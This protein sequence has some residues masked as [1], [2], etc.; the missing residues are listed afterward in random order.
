MSRQIQS[1]VS[2]VAK[3]IGSFTI[4]SAVLRSKSQY[5]F[6]YSAPTGTTATS[7]GIIGT[8]TPNGFEWSE[9][10]GIQAQGF[11]SGFD[12]SNIE[13]IYHGDSAGYVYNHNKGNSFNPAGV[14]TSVDARYKTPNL[15]F[16]DAGTLKSLHYAKI[17]FTPEGAIQPNLKVSYDFDSLDR[18]QPPL[19]ALDEIPTPAVF[20]SVASLFGSSVFGSSGDP[21]V[22]IAVQG[23][24][25]NIAFKIFS[26]DTKA[27][28]SINGFYIDYSPSGRR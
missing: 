13:Q 7:K 10:I 21:M 8:I 23:S 18:L 27:P 26:Q 25:H 3:S 5:R 28:Y 4:S 1:V 20:G 15:D 11:A 24:G 2:T 17:S 22:R 19:Y 16:G 9:T 12:F 14:A 6:F